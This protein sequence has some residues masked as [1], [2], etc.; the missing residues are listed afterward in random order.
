MKLPIISN[1]EVVPL[2]LIPYVTYPPVTPELL[3]RHLYNERGDYFPQLFAHAKEAPDLDIAPESWRTLYY[4]CKD[5]LLPANMFVWRRDLEKYTQ[6]EVQDYDE[7][8]SIHLS[9]LLSETLQSI[10]FAGFCDETPLESGLSHAPP[11][12]L[13]W[14]LVARAALELQ[15]SSGN[16]PK[17]R[18][19]ISKLRHL[20]KTEDQARAII[21]SIDKEGKIETDDRTYRT[22]TVQNRLTKIKKNLC[23]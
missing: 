22:K 12:D 17:Y 6:I 1:S 20:M 10:A 21:K 14:Q 23:K 9:Q 11:K 15:K 5:G 2:R 3:L 18:E 19:V 8:V 4:A 13:I 16:F 7:P